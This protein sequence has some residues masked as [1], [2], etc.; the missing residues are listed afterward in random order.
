M[1]EKL[2]RKLFNKPSPRDTT[3]IQK[4]YIE[5][6]SEPPKITYDTSCIDNFIGQKKNISLIRD[7]IIGRGTNN[8]LMGHTLLFGDA[9]Y[10]KTTLGRLISKIYDAPFVQIGGM[11]STPRDI[12]EKLEYLEPNSVFFIDEI[13]ALSQR[14]QECLYEPMQDGTIDGRPISKFILVAATT[15]VAK[16]SKPLNDRFHLQLKME[17]YTLNELQNIIIASED[18]KYFQKSFEIVEEISKRCKGT[19]RVALSIARSVVNRNMANPLEDIRD[20]FILVMENLGIEKDGLDKRDISY[21]ECLR[22]SKTLSLTTISSKLSEHP[23]DIT[24]IESTLIKQDL[25]E[26]TRSGRTLTEKGKARIN[27]D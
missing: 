16:L 14:S 1:F 5:V 6:V 20:S 21:L 11:S 17:D 2:L 19:P 9:G 13:H 22:N 26:I 4:N 18:G 27:A 15:N 23:Q 8:R 3:E 25:I 12:I 7:N 10:G 24:R